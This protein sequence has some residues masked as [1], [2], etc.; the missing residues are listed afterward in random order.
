MDS[1][2]EL[3]ALCNKNDGN[4]LDRYV[5]GLTRVKLAETLTWTAWRDFTWNPLF[6]ACMRRADRWIVNTTTT[7]SVG[8][9]TFDTT[10]LIAAASCRHSDKVEV[11]LAGGADYA[12]VDDGQCSALRHACIEWYGV[13]TARKPEYEKEEDHVLWRSVCTSAYE[14]VIRVIT[15]HVRFIGASLDALDPDG[16]S[17]MSECTSLHGAS[18]LVA[19]LLNAGADPN[20]RSR[21]GRTPIMN[22]ASA[23]DVETFTLLVTHGADPYLRDEDGRS[24]IDVV[25]TEDRRVIREYLAQV[26]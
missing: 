20:A 18:V 12:L 17:A 22:A 6:Y 4:A 3:Q 21:C 13:R 2:Y 23:D 15:A 8:R 14:D 16:E 9:R 10:P 11:L 24:A 25:Y 26:R 1:F 7:I 19:I 5:E